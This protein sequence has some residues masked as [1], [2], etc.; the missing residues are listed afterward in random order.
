[1]ATRA[2]IIEK[3]FSSFLLEKKGEEIY[4]TAKAR[5][6]LELVPADLKK[7]ELT[8]IWEMKLSQIAKGQLQNRRFMQ[9]IRSYAAELVDEIRQGS[10]TFPP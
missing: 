10:G 5:Q 3:L 4:T 1:M 7:P 6:L 9:D 2:D 8:A